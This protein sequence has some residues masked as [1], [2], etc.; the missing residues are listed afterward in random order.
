MNAD[1]L[2]RATVFALLFGGAL[3]F[4]AWRAGGFRAKSDADETQAPDVA[5]KPEASAAIGPGLGVGAS[6]DGVVSRDGTTSIDGVPVRYRAWTVSWS[7]STP[8]KSADPA[9]GVQDLV[10]PRLVLFPAPQSTKAAPLKPGDPSTTTVAAKTAVL[11]FEKDVRTEARLAGDVAVDRIDPVRGDFH[12]RTESLVCTMETNGDLDKR[13]AQTAAPVVI[14]GGRAHVSGTGLDADLSGDAVVATILHEVKGRFDAAAGSMSMVGG[15]T[16]GKSLPTDVTCS[17][18]CEIASVGAAKRGVD[19][20]WK[21]T[22][23]DNVHV[24][25]GA[26]S[27]DCDLLEVEFKMGE[28]KSAEGF[29]AQHVVATGRV[30]VKGATESRTFD[31]TCGKA[32]HRRE[33]VVGKEKDVVVFEDAP[34][35]NTYGPLAMAATA[36][37][38]TKKSEGR[39]RMEIRCDGAATMTTQR[40]GNLPTSPHRTNVVFLKNVVVTQW[41]DEKTADATGELRAQKA[42]LYGTRL[43]TGA[44]QPDTLTAE[45]EGPQGGPG[46]DLK[47]LDFSSHSGAATWTRRA[48][49]DVETYML[50]DHPVVHYA[51]VRALHPFGKPTTSSAS[52]VDVESADNVTVEV[53]AERPPVAGQ[54]PRPFATIVA[55]PRVVVTQTEDGREVGRVTCDDE[56]RATIAAGKQLEHVEA[57]RNARFVGVADDGQTREVTGAKIIVDRLVL[58]PGAPKDAPHPAQVVALGDEATKTQAVAVVVEPNGDRDEVRADSLRYAQDGAVVFA[59]GHVLTTIDEKSRAAKPDSGAPK[60]VQGPVRITAAEA[61]VDLA[62]DASKTPGGRKLLKV[63]AGGGVVVDGT[64][65][66][67]EGRQLTYDAVTGIAEVRGEQQTAHVVYSAEN[68]RYPSLLFADVI[69]AYFDVSD[70]PAKKGGLM[71]VEC[72]NGGRIIRYLDAP[73]A[74]T[75]KPA[76]GSTPRRIMIQSNGPMESTRTEASARDEVIAR[77]HSL[78][79]SGEWTKEVATFYGQRVRM[80]FDPDAPGRARD[81]LRTLDALGDDQRQ[82]RVETPEFAGRAD[83]VELDGP[84]GT[85]KLSTSSGPD[86]YVRQLSTGRQM[87]YDSVV[88]HYET[89]EWSDEVRGREVESAPAPKIEKK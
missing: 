67:I 4:L 33:G 23:H 65:D 18:A 57:N 76:A 63:D 10:Q 41:D 8:K 64:I 13:H 74:A 38:A 20:R 82:V 85:I 60:V 31:V 70:D 77:V 26:D 69:R 15:R 79:P 59:N 53:Y 36:A 89:H 42:T 25:Q 75:G 11:T 7:R 37:G 44:F 28:T 56:M 16:D 68:T 81:R 83:R 19:R 17:G 51:G 84:A 46:V 9:V 32:T 21:A 2:R 80:T 34:V 6:E 78:E 30:R 47:R 45:N 88:Y 61:R 71:R 73:D 3:G 86:V 55:G 35:M 43:P 27:L 49:A 24:V 48:D 40:P 87:M 52:R 50:V 14:D 39:G 66:R 5:A 1:L 29:P 54:P 22:F 58:P 62:P 12:L 72:P